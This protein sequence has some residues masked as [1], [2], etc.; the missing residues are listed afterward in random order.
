MKMIKSHN[1]DIPA[2]GLGTWELRRV[3]CAGIVAQAL[4]IGYRHVDTAEFYQN[5]AEVGEGIRNSGIKR[6][7]VFVTMGHQFSR[8]RGRT[9]A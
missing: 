5:E 4:R 3:N 8:S 2:V 9:C 7:S 6:E 1:A